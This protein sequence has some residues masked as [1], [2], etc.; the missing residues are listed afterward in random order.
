[1]ENTV[2]YFEGILKNSHFEFFSRRLKT[3]NLKKKTKEGGQLLVLCD[4][5]SKSGN[6]IVPN[7]LWVCCQDI[8]NPERTIRS[9]PFKTK[10]FTATNPHNRLPSHFCLGKTIVSSEATANYGI[11]LRIPLGKPR[12]TSIDILVHRHKKGL[13]SPAGPRDSYRVNGAVDGKMG[14]KW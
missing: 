9:F 5:Y 14:T 1:M 13:D 2:K 10:E 6:T 7:H 4:E 3:I 8:Y 12:L 11:R